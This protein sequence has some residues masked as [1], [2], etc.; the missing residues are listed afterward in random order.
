MIDRAPPVHSLCGGCQVPLKVFQAVWSDENP[1]PTV[2]L[3]LLDDD[4]QPIATEVLDVGPFDTTEDLG[5]WL[6]TRMLK[7]AGQLTLW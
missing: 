3:S 2:S 5:H 1:W 6:I 4:R 7:L